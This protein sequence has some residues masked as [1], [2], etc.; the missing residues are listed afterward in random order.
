MFK[1]LIEAQLKSE[2][3]RIHTYSCPPDC[4]PEEA[5]H[6]LGMIRTHVFDQMKAQEAK[7]AEEKELEKVD[8]SVEAEPAKEEVIEP[9][10]V[11]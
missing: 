5:Y 9:E 7:E 10:V 3:G 6:I 1:Q 8:E 2:S 11:T 4:P